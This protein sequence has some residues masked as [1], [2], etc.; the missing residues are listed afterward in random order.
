MRKKADN[1]MKEWQ[2]TLQEAKNLL[3]LIPEINEITEQ[4]FEDMLKTFVQRLGKATYQAMRKNYPL[5]LN[6]NELLP[7]WNILWEEMK[8]VPV[9]NFLRDQWKEQVESLSGI[10]KDSCVKDKK[11]CIEEAGKF[12]QF[13]DKIC[14]EIGS[15]PKGM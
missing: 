14:W 10:L 5:I 1:K 4:N 6:N 15:K 9:P 8:N 7:Q 2:M 13:V 12:Y 11:Q 3:D